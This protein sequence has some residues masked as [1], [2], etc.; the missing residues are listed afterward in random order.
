MKTHRFIDSL[1]H[2]L[3]CLVICVFI[4]APLVSQ[5]EELA[6]AQN[7]AVQQMIQ[8]FNPSD[9]AD[10]N[11]VPVVAI[12]AVFGGPVCVLLVLILQHYR[13]Q[14]RLA[15]YRR[16]AIA[17]LIDAGKDVP[18]SLLFFQELTGPQQ[19]HK[20]VQ[21]GLVSVGFGLGI[22]I[23]LWAMNGLAAGTFGLIFVGIGAAQLIAWQLTRTQQNK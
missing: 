6:A 11:L 10:S 4:A 12:V 13:T 17:K 14:M 19:P 20:N 1:G 5:A 15:D 3:I 21:R 9:A 2:Y 23:F 8:S 22:G 7:P 16:E 18:E